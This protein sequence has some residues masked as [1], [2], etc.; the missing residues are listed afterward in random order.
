LLSSRFMTLFLKSRRLSPPQPPAQVQSQAHDQEHEH[1]HLLLLLLIC[2]LS[3]FSLHRSRGRQS[4][5]PDPTLQ[6]DFALF[7]TLL[8]S[9]SL[10]LST[11]RRRSHC[12]WMRRLCLREHAVFRSLSID[13][14]SSLLL[15][16]TSLPPH[17]SNRG[18]SRSFCS[19]CLM[20][21]S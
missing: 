14:S 4:C 10:L 1:E 8:S 12:S 3:Y 18:L 2:C 19:P 16:P 9:P 11:P 21:R 7:F 20:S 13:R 6:L 15:P 5:L 17:P